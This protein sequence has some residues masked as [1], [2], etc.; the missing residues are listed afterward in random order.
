MKLTAA[1]AALAVPHDLVHFRCRDRYLVVNPELAAWAVLDADGLAVLRALAGRPRQPPPDLP[2]V[3]RTLAELALNW[4]IYLPGRQP[5][6]TEPEP[7]LRQ[8][9]YAITDGCNLRCPYCYASSTRRLP[10]ELGTEQSLDLVDQVAALGAEVVIFTG[11]EPM[12]R[13]DL[14]EVAEHARRRGLRA[15]M[16]SNGTRIRDLPTAR[17]IAELFSEVTISLDGGTAEVHEVTRGQGTFAQ[18]ARGLA[19]LNEAGVAPYINHVVTPGNIDYLDRLAEFVGGLRF[20]RV[21]LMSHSKIGRGA[22]DGVQFTFDEHLRLQRFSWVHPLASKLL[23]DGPRPV[24][25]CSIRGNCGLGGNEI[26]VNSLGDVYPCKLITDREHKAGNL[27]QSSLADLYAS[28]V[29]ANFRTNSVFHGENLEDCHRCYIRAGCGGGCRAYHMAGS[30][31]VHRNSRAHCRILRHTM[32][33]NIWRSNGFTGRDLMDHQADMT[34]PLLVRDDAVHP[35]YDDWRT[36]AA[37]PEAVPASAVR[38]LPVVATTGG[39]PRC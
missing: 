1:W 26:Y 35:V 10:G 7:V 33:S 2:G 3:E 25:P 38:L 13:G 23:T 30:G 17:R 29:L 37:V 12:L 28:P 31:D 8:V 39:G 4:L 32:I 22:G 24:K 11:G 20:T 16:I 34:T 21:R 15:N 19:L 18:T 6:V 5:T 9:Y 14:F 27:R 36:E